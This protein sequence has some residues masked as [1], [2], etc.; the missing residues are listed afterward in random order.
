MEV[1]VKIE[2]NFGMK[3]PVFG[4][5]KST[6]RPMNAALNYVAIGIFK[7]QADIDSYPHWQGKTGDVKFKDVN[8]DGVIDGL[9]RVRAT[10]T[11]LPTFV[12]DLT[13]I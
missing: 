10:K 12:E 1:I 4:I 7:D 2:F 11:T 3:L 6:G 5:P 9:D 8:E 13:L